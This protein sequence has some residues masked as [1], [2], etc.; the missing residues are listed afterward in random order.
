MFNQ[1]TIDAVRE[2][3]YGLT[4]DEDASITVETYRE[5]QTKLYVASVQIGTPTSTLAITER[6]GSVA[7]A[8]GLL[9]SKLAMFDL[10]EKKDAA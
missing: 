8:A 9:W 2:V 6:A 5:T 4:T 3:L 7:E 1:T 10:S